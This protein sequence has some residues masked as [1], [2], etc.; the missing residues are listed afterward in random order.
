MNVPNY[1]IYRRDNGHDFGVHMYVKQSLNA[2]KI[3]AN[4]PQE[5]SIEVLWL[6]I[7]NRKL[8]AFIIGCLYR[9]LKAH[10]ISFDYIQDVLHHMLMP[11]KTIFLLGDLND[12]L[13]QSNSKIS[14]IIKNKKLLQVIEKPTRITP[15]SATL[16]DVIIT[17]KLHIVLSSDMIPHYVADHDLITITVNIRKPKFSTTLKT[18]RDLSHCDKNTFWWQLLSEVDN[19]NQILNTDNLNE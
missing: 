10:S 5:E 8:P 1:T 13:L 15:T 9:H 14:L 16:L 17:N 2:I 6:K 3:K 18:F 12:D 4:T 19:L 7:R 11:K